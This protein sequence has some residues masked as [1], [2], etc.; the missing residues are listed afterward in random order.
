L[1]SKKWVIRIFAIGFII[2]T[3]T[4]AY[5]VAYPWIYP[6]YLG[7]YTDYQIT[8]Y[9]AIRGLGGVAARFYYVMDNTSYSQLISSDIRGGTIQKV[10]LEMPSEIGSG[11]YHNVWII[12]WIQAVRGSAARIDMNFVVRAYSI[13]YNLR[14]FDPKPWFNYVPEDVEQYL[15]ENNYFPTHSPEVQRVINQVLTGTIDP[16]EKARRLYEWT[17]KN[18]VYSLTQVGN[19]DV[20]WILKHRIAVCEGYAFVLATLCRAAGIPARVVVGAAALDGE[21]LQFDDLLHAWVEV[22]LYWTWVACDPTWGR[23]KLNEYWAGLRDD[24]AFPKMGHPL[25]ITA[26]VM[27]DVTAIDWGYIRLTGYDFG[28]VHIV[29]SGFAEPP[30]DTLVRILWL[31]TTCS[32]IAGISGAAAIVYWWSRKRRKAVRPPLIDVYPLNYCTFCGKRVQ[33]DSIYCDRCGRKIR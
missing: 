2:S 7:R 1:G 20:P 29:G 13:S 12:S 14:G 25:H 9:V 24:I 31:G 18:I 23:D 32:T 28:R 21:S 26:G 30:K 10:S 8:S 6:Y 11:L 3:I 5:Q 16:S 27:Y 19:V 15:V 4:V 22:Y 33:P 17:T